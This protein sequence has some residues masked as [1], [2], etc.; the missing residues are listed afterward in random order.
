MAVDQPPPNPRP[1]GPAPVAEPVGQYNFRATAAVAFV[2]GVIDVLIA[3]R[4]FLK[5][6][7]ASAQS[8]FVNFIYGVSSPLVAPFHGIFPNSGSGANTF[9]SGSLVALVVYALI[10]WGIVVLIRILTAPR[11]SRP[12]S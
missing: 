2:V 3:V 4:F 12:A 7:G 9:E 1:V 11:G 10:G 6:L 8:G 5:L